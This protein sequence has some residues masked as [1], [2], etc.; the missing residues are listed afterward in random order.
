MASPDRD[1]LFSLFHTTGGA[2]WTRKGNWCTSAE[3]PTW[4]WVKVN[5]QGRVVEL[6]LSDNNLQG[7]R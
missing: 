3:L 1:A 5:Q 6:D 2:N 7:I 4:D